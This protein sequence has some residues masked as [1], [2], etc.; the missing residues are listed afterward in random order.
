MTPIRIPKEAERGLV[1]IINLDDESIERVIAA[2]ADAPPTFHPEKLAEKTAAKIDGV[3]REDI[4]SIVYTLTSLYT[5][6]DY[7]DS[8][9]E[10]LVEN[11][12]RAIAQGGIAG[13][14]VSDVTLGQFRT[15]LIRLLSLDS[16]SVRSRSLSLLLEQDH[17]F[18]NA[19]ILTDIRPLFA[20]DLKAAPT[21][22]LIVHTLR[23]SYHQGGELKEFYVA[24]DSEDI[25]ALTDV[26]ERANSKA[27]NLKSVL[28]TAR[29]TCLDV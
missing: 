28:E 10:Q 7:F 3:S 23:L 1:S 11:V 20:S 27:E 9:I 16:I 18:W 12:G 19:R 8:S 4:D 21:A 14:E 2:L 5:A 13:L 29:I 26:L 17:A 24:M 25:E 6:L 22:A 15:R